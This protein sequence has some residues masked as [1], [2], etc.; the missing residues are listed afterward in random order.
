MSYS[1]LTNVAG[2]LGPLVTVPYVL[3][4]LGPEAYGRAVHALILSTWI[5]SVLVLGMSNYCTR[6][7]SS[8]LL[9]SASDGDHELSGLVSL[10]IFAACIGTLL[11]IIVIAIA[12]IGEG[13]PDPI[14]LI[15][16]G[17]TLLSFLNVDWFFYVADRMDIFFWRTAS[18]RLASIAVLFYAVRTKS[19]V[20]TYAAISAIFIVL[21]NVVSFIFVVRRHPLRFDVSAYKRLAAARYFLANASVGSIYQFADQ[22][23]M[24][25]LS[26]KEN[27]AYLNVCKQILAVANMVVGSA[28]RVLMPAAVHAFARGR[29]R[30]YICKTASVCGATVILLALGMWLFGG[31]AIRFFAG[32]KFDAASDHMAL[33]A[34]IFVATSVAVYIDTQVSIPLHRERF[35][36]VS[37]TFVAVISVTIFLAFL[38]RVGFASALLGLLGGETVGVFVMLYLH[39]S[40]SAQVAGEKKLNRFATVFD[41]FDEQHFHKDV[42]CIPAL[43]SRLKFGQTSIIIYRR[44]KAAL[45]VPP[46]FTADL[47][48]VELGARSKA[49]FYAKALAYL[50]GNKEITVVNLYH[51]SKEN[52][53]FF[54]LLRLIR[55][56]ITRY[57]KLDMDLRSLAWITTRRI[58]FGAFKSKVSLFMAG[59]IDLISAETQAIFRP[60]RDHASAFR[61]NLF[62][63]P[64]GI[65]AEHA[66][67]TSKVEQREKV[68]LCVGRIGTAQKNNELAIDAFCKLE[69]R[70]GWRIVFAGP[71]EPDFEAMIDGLLTKRPD[72]A[73]A[74][75]LTGPLDKTHLYALYA[76][77]S[78]FC[79][80]SRWEGFA[81]V[82]SE[83]AYFGNYIVTTDVGG[84]REIT[85]NGRFGTIVENGTTDGFAQVFQAIVDGKI[86]LETMRG[87][88]QAYCASQMTWESLVA[89][90]QSRIRSHTTQNGRT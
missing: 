39:S 78:V 38:H 29:R 63:M 42:G 80:T 77:A 64:N 55:P 76:K 11:H 72:L 53:F 37:N 7:Y 45:S 18:L 20:M 54:E 59:R 74:I 4:V 60:L 84:A 68:I 2:L 17:V 16:V 87:D 48:L 22:F 44:K 34:A 24:G 58:G 70:E 1:I 52:L 67:S 56:D 66:S 61:R 33:L 41:D 40:S 47:T 89:L 8:R 30:A 46:E 27:L 14:Y 21:P 12:F 81:L 83:A 5:T 82:L 69:R 65:W 35:T 79:L 25:I 9:Q 75:E 62:F 51:F 15:Y 28:S 19:D 49:I 43:Y 88:Q 57:L 36:T 85:D 50:W 3:R 10:Q 71:V 13:K 73:C 32:P 26:T 6:Q 23:L 86:D 31:P 90:L